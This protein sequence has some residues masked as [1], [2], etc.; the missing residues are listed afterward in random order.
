MCLILAALPVGSYQHAAGTSLQEKPMLQA[1][2]T[3]PAFS[4]FDKKEGFHEEKEEFGEE[5]ED[6]DIMVSFENPFFRVCAL[7]VRS[8]LLEYNVFT[9]V[10]NDLASLLGACPVSPPLCVLFRIY[11]S[12][13][14]RPV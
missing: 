4:W 3:E 11:R 8:K 13:L 14:L 10:D 6:Q 12:R 1:G 5:E 7:P 9:Y 2:D